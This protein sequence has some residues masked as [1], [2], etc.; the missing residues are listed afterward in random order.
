M[1]GATWNPDADLLTALTGGGEFLYQNQIGPTEFTGF[2]GYPQPTLLAF[3]AEDPNLIVAGGADSGVYLST[4]A[5]ASWRL[6]TD[7]LGTEGP[8]IPHLP[9]P[10]FAHFDHEQGDPDIYIGT[11]GRGVWRVAVDFTMDP[12]RFEP[13][14][15][16][17]SSTVLG[18]PP[19][20]IERDLT[21][22]DPADADFF[23]YTAQDTGKLIINAFFNGL[24]GDLD[25]RAGTGWAI[26]SP[27][28]SRAM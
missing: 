7:P 15:T 16:I 17:A 1:A 2:G 22:H 26:S 3:D 21:I 9:R 24:Q 6:L 8:D 5:G 18:S 27:R 19:K 20:I 10:R 23:Q 4:D 13:N 11:Q 12:D 14:D 25:L 28:A